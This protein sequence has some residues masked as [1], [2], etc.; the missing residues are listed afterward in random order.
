VVPRAVLDAVVKRK[1]PSPRQKSNPRTPIVQAVAQSYNIRNFTSNYSFHIIF[2]ISEEIS[3][4][5]F[6]RPLKICEEKLVNERS[7]QATVN[8]VQLH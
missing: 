8:E 5:I 2:L 1:F 7:Q 3:R 6:D 4:R